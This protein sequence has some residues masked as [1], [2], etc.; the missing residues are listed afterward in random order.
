MSPAE[1]IKLSDYRRIQ[2][3]ALDIGVDQVRKGI[4]PT[5]FVLIFGPHHTELVQ[6]PEIARQMGEAGKQLTVQFMRK[7]IAE[8]K[9]AGCVVLADMFVE[10]LEHPEDMARIHRK[11]LTVAELR[12]LGRTNRRECVCAILE[13]PFL[14]RTMMQ[15]Y[16]RAEGEGEFVLEE[17]F[18]GEPDRA[19][20]RFFQLFPN[21]T[22]PRYAPPAPG[23]KTQ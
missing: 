15:Y 3:E 20:G 23:E 10:R 17:F 6:V 8:I 18:E 14:I 19:G 9:P 7:T 2:R 16:N 4:P 1:T 22:V 11:E 21:S 5:W 13:T 12:A